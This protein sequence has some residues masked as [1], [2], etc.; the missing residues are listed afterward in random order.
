VGTVEAEMPYA[1]ALLSALLQLTAAVLALR[2]VGRTR[3]L[4]WLLLSIALVLMTARRI[5]ALRPEREGTLAFELLG[6]L[7]SLLMLLAVHG[8]ARLFARSTRAQRTTAALHEIEQKILA[9]EPAEEV[10]RTVAEKMVELLGIPLAWIG[11]PGE[12]GIRVG[13]AAG[14]M[15]TSAEAIHAHDPRDPADICL[16]EETL[17]TGAEVTCNDL[18]GPRASAWSRRA[19]A[20]GFR[21]IVAVPLRAGNETAGVLCVCARRPR[22]LGPEARELLRFFSAGLG[23]ALQQARHLDE[24]RVRTAVLETVANAVVI[25]GRDGVI[26]W[27][28]RAFTQLTGYEPA[29]AVGRTPRILNS[30]VH[31]QTFFRSLW[32][33]I[34]GGRVWHGEMT[35]RRKDG[36]L[37][38]EEQTITPLF[39]TD[40]KIARFVAVKQDISARKAAEERVQHLALHDSLTDLPNRRAMEEELRRA[41]ERARR[42]R[43]SAL[44]LLD[45]D[46]FKVVNDTRGHPAGDRVLVELAGL[47]RSVIRPSDT[48]ARLGGDEFVVLVEEDHPGQGRAIAERLRQLVDGHRFSGAGGAFE[49]TASVGLVPVDGEIDAAGMLA[50]ADAAL[51]DAKEGGRN[52]IGTL[53]PDGASGSRLAEAG[54]WM[55]RIKEALRENGFVLQYQPIVRLATGETTQWEALLRLR[56]GSAPL[57]SPGE[58]LPTADR[59]G[60]SPWID[61][62]VTRQAVSELARRPGLSLWVNLAGPTLRN[63]ELLA[64]IEGLLRESRVAPGRLS[65][66]ITEAAAVADVSAALRWMQ[67]LREMGCRFALDDFGSGF[68]SF[69]YLQTLPADFVKIDAS[70][71]KGLETDPANRALVNAIVAVSRA[72]GKEMIAEGIESPASIAVLREL[73]VE[74]GQGWALGAP[75]PLPEPVGEPG[76]APKSLSCE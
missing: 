72:L 13:A 31:G 73:G 33:T 8:V 11:L 51:Y 18:S 62:W 54:R 5:L 71:V 25:T 22:A 69:Q 35:N 32:E 44:L 65:F 9:L 21:R 53:R 19:F 46:N 50:L 55:S 39:G 20:A 47:L 43:P 64:E 6:L 15:A 36:T 75:G 26:Q 1:L 38:V 74:Y 42:G 4:G 10:F 30:G 57:I 17:R 76:R 23:L 61:R 48:L 2:L 68:S 12:Q 70:F 41:A 16:V 63:M 7:A 52:R 34:Q 37:Y 60:L 14:E 59:F 66:E 29:E 28:N 67:R 45:L 3:R 58:F 27:V 24:I 49:L 40:G 56:D